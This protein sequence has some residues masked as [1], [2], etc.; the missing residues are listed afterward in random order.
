MSNNFFNNMLSDIHT[1][2]QDEIEK[3]EKTDIQNDDSGIYERDNTDKI[4]DTLLAFIIPPSIIIGSAIASVSNEL[5]FM[6][7]NITIHIVI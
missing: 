5:K 2:F 4:I 6:M 3:I 1:E 7:I